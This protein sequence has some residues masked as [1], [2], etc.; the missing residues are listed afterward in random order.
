LSG[1]EAQRVALARAL[2][3]APDL[4]ML[5]EPLGA[6]DRALRDQ[7]MDDLRRLLRAASQTAIYVT[8]DQQEA[9]T[10]A[11]RVAVMRAGH[12]IQSGA[13][14]EI[15]RRPL[16]PSVARLLGLTNLLDAQLVADG[17]VETAIGRFPVVA[18]ASHPPV[19]GMLLIRPEAACLIPGDAAIRLRVRVLEHLF[20]GSQMRL[21]VQAE[22]GGPPLTF[23]F[24]PQPLPSVGQHIE[25]GLQPDRLLWLPPD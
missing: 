5:D 3:P 20:R 13:P 14:E 1:G 16:S 7:L 6:L 18:P 4:L 19:K 9:F 17:K 15:Y 8:H 24:A 21:V 22:S 2:A 23:D 12:I 25:I 11:D 10:I